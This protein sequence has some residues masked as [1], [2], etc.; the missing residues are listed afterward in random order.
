MKPGTLEAQAD[1]A[2]AKAHLQVAEVNLQQMQTMLDYAVLRAPYSGVVI[3]TLFTRRH[4][5]KPGA[6][7]EMEPLFVVMRMDKVRIFVDVPEQE[8]QLVHPGIP[9]RVR[10]QA[11]QDQE[12][13][14]TVTR[15]SWALDPNNRTLRAEIELPNPNGDLRP[16]MYAYANI[17][18]DNPNTWTLPVAAVHQ[19][20]K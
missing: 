20:D 8:V 16:G 3:G 11:L 12:I 18:V 4:L 14:A 5:L 6:M 13:E 19:D 15:T 1:I 2:A 9:A 10:I 17:T 7:V